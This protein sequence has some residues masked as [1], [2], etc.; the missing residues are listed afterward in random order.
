MGFVFEVVAADVGKIK[1]AAGAEQGFEE[2]VA[3]VVAAGTVAGL[4][5]AGDVVARCLSLALDAAD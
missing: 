2:Q 5:V 4:G 1:V 3:V